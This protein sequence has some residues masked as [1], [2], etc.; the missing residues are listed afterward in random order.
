MLIGSLRDRRLAL[1]PV[2]AYHR[3]SVPFDPD[4][5]AAKRD[6]HERSDRDASTPRTCRRRSAAV[7]SGRAAGPAAARHGAVS[8]LVHAAGGGA[9]ELGAPDRRGDRQ[10]QADRRVHPARR[11]GRGA[12]A[13]RPLSDRHRDAHPQDVQAARRQPAADRPGA[14]AAA[15]STRSSQTQ[16]Y[17]RAAVTRRRRRAAA[18]RTASRST[19]CAQHQEQL[20]A[21][22]VAVAAAVRRPA[23]A[24]REHHRAR[25]ARRLHR[26]EPDDDQHAGQAGGARDA[27]HPRADGHAEPDPDQGARGAR[28]RIED[29]V[30]GAVR[31]RQEPARVLPA[32]ADEGDPEG[33][34]RRRRPDQGDRGARARRSK[35]PACPRR[36]R[37]KRCA[38][39]IGCR[40]CRSPPPSTPC[41]APTSTGSS[42][43]R[44]PSGPRKS[45][46]LPQTKERARRRPLGPREGR[47]TASSSTSPCAS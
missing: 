6:R 29:P 21:G 45:I 35:P 26:L 34:R 43:C 23:D 11:G 9:R 12:A 15:R 47:R 10:R 17:L 1:R 8:E 14:R 31:G 30:A 33:A 28:A 42:R 37:R 38:S 16:P 20:P 7:D 41:R 18:T 40:R 25:P 39:S 2:S 44:G 27:R 22:R 4:A 5:I 24:R 13:G 19:R 32:R 46:D 3:P 36:S